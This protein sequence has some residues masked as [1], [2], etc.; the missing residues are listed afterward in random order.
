MPQKFKALASISAW[1]LFVFGLLVIAIA[2]FMSIASGQATPAAGPP[3]IQA[4]AAY[5]VGVA[6]IIL[7]VVAMKLRQMLE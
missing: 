2:A 7:S 5:S 3:P 4:Y 1:V 6:S